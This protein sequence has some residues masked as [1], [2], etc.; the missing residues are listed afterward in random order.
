[1][2]SAKRFAEGRFG[3][4]KPSMVPSALLN[5]ALKPAHIKGKRTN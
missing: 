4:A 1:M 5:L 3:K 2:L